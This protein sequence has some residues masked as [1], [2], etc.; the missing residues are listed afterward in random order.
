MTG[1]TVTAGAIK[2]IA[3][4]GVYGSGTL[5]QSGVNTTLNEPRGLAFNSATG[6]LFI[7][8]YYN[9]RILKLDSAG[10]ISHFAGV[11]NGSNTDGLARTSAKCNYPNEI[12][13]DAADDKLFVSCYGNNGA[14]DGTIKYFKLSADEGYSLV[15]FGTNVEGLLGYVNPARTRRMYSLVKHPG[16]KIIYGADLER[17]EVMAF[18]YGDTESYYGGDLVLPANEMIR[19][20]QNDGCGNNT[21]RLWNDAAGSIRAYSIALKM[22]GASLEGWF[23]S[24]NN[25]RRILFLNNTN[26]SITLG[27]RTVAAKSYNNIFGDGSADYSR[28]KPAYTSSYLNS[29][30]GIYASATTLYIG[31][32]SNYKI[33]TLDISTTN[34]DVGDLIGSVKKGDYNGETPA[35]LNSVQLNAPRSLSYNS[36]DNSIYFNDDLN[37]RIRKINLTTGLLSTV[38]GRGAS[39]AVNTPIESNASVY[40]RNQRGLQVDGVN[41]LVFYTD[42]ETNNDSTSRTCVARVSNYGTSSKSVYGQTINSGQTNTIAGNYANGCSTWQGAYENTDATQVRLYEPWGIVSLDDL[43][44]L[45]ISGNNS[46]CI[47][48]VNSSGLITTSIGS[49]NNA[50]DIS[51][52]FATARLNNPGQLILDSDPALRAA[53]NFFVVDRTFTTNSF[54]K[55]ANFSGATVRVAGIDIPDGHIVKIFSTLNYVSSVSSFEN[56]ICYSQ[57]ATS[58]ADNYAQNVTCINRSTGITSFRVGSSAASAVKGKVQELTSDEGITGTSVTLAQPLGLTFDSEGNLYISNYAN[59]TIKKVMKWW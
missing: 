46:H 15:R 47:N 52:A 27:G 5:G 18:S 41:E 32:R 39:G 58:D 23:L 6:D 48:K 11:V 59:Y 30:L 16:K 7:A 50:A 17:C 21:N 12:S 43:S 19:L 51:G 10:L 22:N 20:T 25:D 37:Y 34:G 29:P 57:G 4:T 28:V 26:A 44:A 54:V 42:T 35:L 49:C 36:T 9:H 14:S 1:V 40:M 24:N 33:G 13:L 55:Y 56:Q 8:E 38:V 3:G 53:G 2:V 31:D 45:Y